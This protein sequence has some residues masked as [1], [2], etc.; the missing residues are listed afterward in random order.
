LKGLSSNGYRRTEYKHPYLWIYTSLLENF[1]VKEAERT[2]LAH[3]IRAA[4]EDAA[5]GWDADGVEDDS[6]PLGRYLTEFGEAERSSFISSLDRLLELVTT[7]VQLL[8]RMTDTL[9]AELAK[10]VR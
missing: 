4:L 10:V 7:H 5:K 2:T 1:R 6:Q 3:N 8:F 9:E